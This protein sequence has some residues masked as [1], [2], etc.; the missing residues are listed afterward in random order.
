[1]DFNQEKEVSYETVKQRAI[2]GV[3]I[4]TGRTFILQIVSQISI[5]LLTILLSPSQFGVFFLVSAVINFFAYFSDIGLAAALI[6]KKEKLEQKD[7]RTVFT[8]QQLLVLSLVVLI[9]LLTPIFKNWY[10]FSQDAVYLLWA[11]SLSLFFSSLKTIPSVILERQLNFNKLIIPQVAET[12]VFYTVAVSLAW[13]GLG[14]TSFTWAVLARGATGLLVMYSV[15]PWR[16]GFAFSKHSLKSL[17]SF[18][19]P[20]QL[21]TF[22]A[23]V[24]DDG[25][26]MVL[27]GMLGAS[28]I[29]LLGW[30]Q[31][32]GTAP[33]RFFMDQII[34]VT[35]PTFSRLQD[36][37]KRLSKA[38][39]KSMLLITTLVFPVVVGLVV[40]APALTVVIPKYEKWQPALLALTLIS[41]NSLWAAV[42]TPLTNVL[43]AIGKIKI[44]FW[45]MVMWTV[46]TWITI[47][48]LTLRYGVNGAALG[49][50]IVGTSSIIAI[51]IA[52]KFITVDFINSVGKP[53]I[54]S[55]IMGVILYAFGFIIPKTLVGVFILVVLGVII[56]G[57][58]LLV[59]F[60]REVVVNVKTVL[61]A[62][63]LKEVA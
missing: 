41:F 62:L 53:L 37:Q 46:L 59:M 14:I 23:V 8:I 1:M 22:L 11:L 40:L 35:F 12:V 50:S 13:Q 54:S 34:K 16:P 49:L 56:Y 43:N 24:K 3:A 27:G 39:S 30:A 63:R 44:T 42:T 26:I 21:N 58:L 10:S 2:K 7:L 36:D 55:L 15:Q 28:G 5:F 17:L 32:W 6:Q 60:G 38:V 33:L 45:L 47:P 20:Y 19:L 48:A 61:D 51:F 4:L 25:L 9:F 29:G 31:K 18:G 57:I 52:T